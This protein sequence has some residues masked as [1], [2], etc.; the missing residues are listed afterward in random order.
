MAEYKIRAVTLLLKTL[1]DP[2]T[3][4]EQYAAKAL[5]ASDK[6]SEETGY[7]VETTRI[8]IEGLGIEEW[9]EK[10]LR[11]SELVDN[12]HILVSM[13]AIRLEEAY[14]KFEKYTLIVENDIFSSIIMPKDLSREYAIKASEIIHKLTDRDPSLATRLGINVY[15]EPLVTPYYPLASP[16]ANE[17]GIAVALTYPNYLSSCY[18]RNGLEGLENCVIEAY[19]VAE[20]AGRIASSQLEAEFLGVDLSVAPWMQET[21]LG[22]VELVAGVRMPEPGFLTGIHKVNSILQK[23]A[24]AKKTIGYNEVQLPVAE[25]L[26][27]KAR[28][29]ELETTARDL[30]RFSC[31]CL[32]GLD[33]AVVPASVNGVA[34]LILDTAV[35]SRVKNRPLGVRIVPVEDV[36]PGDKVWLDKFGETPVISI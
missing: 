35:C 5:E 25:D 36:E 32:A 15:G 26:K 34:G 17:K 1:E 10:A 28:V 4:I 11:V 2:L 30:A 22:L 24:S 16:G 18:R 12:Y 27:L 29:S 20:R 6:A 3:V 23:V 13:G 19:S 8:V 9:A 7:P 31:V 33:L 21:S 14:S